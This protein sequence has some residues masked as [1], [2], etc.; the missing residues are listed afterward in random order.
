MPCPTIPRVSTAAPAAHHHGHH[1]DSNLRAAY[2]HVLA[3]ALTSVLAIVGLTAAWAFGWTFIDPAVGLVGMIVILSWALSLIRA[4]GRVL[5]DTVPDPELARRIRER[6]EIGGDRLTDLHLW[7]VGP[8]H[9]AM[10]ASVVSDSPQAPC[11]LQSAA[12]RPGRAVA[13]HHRSE[14]LP[15]LGRAAAER[16]GSRIKTSRSTRCRPLS[17]RLSC[18]RPGKTRIVVPLGI[19]LRNNVNQKIR[20]YPDHQLRGWKCPQNRNGL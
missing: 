16:G 8:G 10:I 3:D 11:G 20:L 19:R 12:R 6:I 1:H 17:A 18:N 15:A 7:Q 14:C 4:A 5:L 9:A 13:R 2:V